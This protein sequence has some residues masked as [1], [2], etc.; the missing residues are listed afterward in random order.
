[1]AVAAEAAQISNSADA[2]FTFTFFK[3]R[4]HYLLCCDN[5]P[6]TMIT[7]LVWLSYTIIILSL[8]SLAGTSIVRGFYGRGYGGGHSTLLSERAATALSP[9][10]VASSTLNPLSWCTALSPLAAATA[11]AEGITVTMEVPTHPL[12]DFTVTTQ[13]SYFLTLIIVAVVVFSHLLLSSSSSNC[14]KGS[15]PVEESVL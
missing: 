14:D 4:F 12:R 5:S 15:D 9:I 2:I 8:H 10:V 1:M 13:T 6:F 7:S 11:A 3:R